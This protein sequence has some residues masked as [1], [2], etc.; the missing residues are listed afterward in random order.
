M[1]EYTGCPG[2]VRI[3]KAIEASM[4]QKF[5]FLRILN[6]GKRRSSE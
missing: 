6:S 5:L 3:V 1:K 2:T 4:S